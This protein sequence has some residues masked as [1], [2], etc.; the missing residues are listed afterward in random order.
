MRVLT[1]LIL[2]ITN[3]Y[4]YS[5]SDSITRALEE[6]IITAQRSKQNQLFT[7]YSV[8][9][10]SRHYLN[11]FNPRT[12]PEALMGV[13]GVFVQKTN[14]GGGSPFIRGLTG[15]QT[16]LLIDG[17]RLNNSTFRYGPNQYLNTIDVYSINR[18]EIAKGTGSVQYGTDALGGV[19]HI[20]TSEPVFSK[21][22][23]SVNGKV[24]GKYMTGNMEQT[25]RGDLGY[26]SKNFGIT[27]GVAYRQF[28]DLMGGDTTGR[29][30]PSG[31]NQWSFDAKAKFA[32]DKNIQLTFAHQFLQQ[33]NVPVYH[34]VKLESFSLNEFD[35]QKRSLSYA[36]LNVQGKKSWMKEIEIIGSWQQTSE[37]RNSQKQGSL[38]LRNERDGIN[39]FGFTI[40]VLSHIKKS[41]T[42][43]SGIELYHDRVNSS[44]QETD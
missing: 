5:Q 35:P 34:K 4:A 31:Y 22:K 24:S 9:S 43:N 8:S 17:I 15:N 3:S 1:V 21:E 30:S 10:V 26:S 39:T 7:P 12:T 20:I 16:L 25:V 33:D 6:V 29:Q 32:L 38:K 27:A 41:W 28:G 42:A 23:R 36:R 13:N 2:A 19:I 37:G 18:I 40:D 44:A 11:D 14:H